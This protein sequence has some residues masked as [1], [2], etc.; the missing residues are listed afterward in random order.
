M[1][2]HLTGRPVALLAGATGPIGRAICSALAADGARVAG[3]SRSG[4]PVDDSALDLVCDVEDPEAIDAAV[5]E[6]ESR[7]G[8][9]EI[10]V[11][12]SHP[13][14]TGSAPV[15]STAPSVLEQQL[16]AVSAH[17]ALCARVVPGMR[18]AGAG[19][20]VYV[21]GALMARPAAGHG[22]YGAAKAAASTLTRFLAV[23]EGR[24]GITANVVA[25]GRVVE[26]GETD[27]DLDPAQADLARRLRE[28]LAL[29]DFPTPEDVARAVALLVASPALT[30]QTIWVTGGEP[31]AC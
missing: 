30:A 13:R 29:A 31:I 12:S 28:Q 24:A 14:A 9:V 23:E 26:A 15:A 22:A 2:P 6:V 11:N 25:P 10:L 4:T 18:R 21:S 8:P 1:T 20:I 7:L 27:D 19:R 3:L 5:A 17:A 16:R